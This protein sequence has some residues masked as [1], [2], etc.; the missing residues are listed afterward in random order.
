[1]VQ[2]RQIKDSSEEEEEE[3]EV[4]KLLGSRRRA[5]DG[6]VSHFYIVYESSEVRAH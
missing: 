1:M 4:E 2:V 3:F 5:D 6:T